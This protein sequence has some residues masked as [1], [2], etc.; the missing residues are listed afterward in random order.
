METPNVIWKK[1]VID[2]SIIYDCFGHSLPQLVGNLSN[3]NGDVKKTTGLITRTSTLLMHHA[4]FYI[5][6]SSLH[7][8][9][10]KLSNVTFLNFDVLPKN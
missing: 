3:H 8:Y 7:D 4:F 10:M 6:W 5:T 9:S 2:L 1:V